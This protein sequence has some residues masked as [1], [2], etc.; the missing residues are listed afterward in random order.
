VETIKYAC[1]GVF[2]LGKDEDYLKAFDKDSLE[3]M[4]PLKRERENVGRLNLKAG[5]KYVIVC[6]TERPGKKA[7]FFLSLYFNQRLRDVKIKRVF[8]P[9][10]RC[11]DEVLPYLIPEE[12]EK[13]TAQTP[14]WKIKLVKESLTY[15]MTDEDQRGQM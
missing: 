14:L 13:M 15:M 8:H 9:N 1:A 2:K 10:D 6:A 12:A 11:K 5:K 4:S 7:K 3:F